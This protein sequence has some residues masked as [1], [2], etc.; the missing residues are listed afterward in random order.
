M[1]G[2][3]I[4]EIGKYVCWIDYEVRPRANPEILQIEF[5]PKLYAEDVQ[6]RCDVIVP[7][8]QTIGSYAMVLK[9]MR[10]CYIDECSLMDMI[11]REL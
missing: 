6:Y 8:G 2:K 5:D 3:A 1:K 7:I 10:D 11:E 4:F 9:Y